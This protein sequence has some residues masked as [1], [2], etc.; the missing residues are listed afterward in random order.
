MVET[1]LKANTRALVIG[2]IPPTLAALL[3]VVLATGMAS[4]ADNAWWRAGGGAV[5]VAATFMVALLLRQ[6]TLPR[7]ACDGE[8]LLVYLTWAAPFRVPLDVV[9]VFFQG[10]GP[11]MLGRKHKN[12]QVATI[13]V[14][15]AERAE[16]WKKRHVKPALGTWCEGYI[17]IRG[18]WCEP[19]NVEVI[20]QLN[21]RLREAKG[22]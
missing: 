17:T 21:R 14:R 6:T 7:L 20:H 3:G 9:E 12:A 22:E 4:A 8:H 16:D 10:Q 15:L 19:I 13:V 5:A 11:A 1:W 2:T 18:T